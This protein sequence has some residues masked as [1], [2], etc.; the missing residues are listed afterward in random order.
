MNLD[1]YLGNIMSTPHT[2]TKLKRPGTNSIPLPSFPSTPT[3]PLLTEPVAQKFDITYW[4]SAVFKHLMFFQHNIV[5]YHIPLGD[6]RLNYIYYIIWVYSLAVSIRGRTCRC[7]LKN[8]HFLITRSRL[9]HVPPSRKNNNN[10]NNYQHNIM[11][12]LLLLS[13]LLRSVP[14]SQTRRRRRRRPV[15][16]A[17]LIRVRRARR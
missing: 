6:R 8:A 2:V 14:N 12:S 5:Y 9:L 13:L 10:S 16:A 17:N 15:S 1:V 4:T 3:L 11:P 7:P